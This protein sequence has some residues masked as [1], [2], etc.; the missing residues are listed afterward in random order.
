[1]DMVKLIKSRRSIRAFSQE[2]PTREVIPY[3]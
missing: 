2:I 3:P 1:M